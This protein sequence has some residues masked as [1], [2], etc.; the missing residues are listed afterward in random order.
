MVSIRTELAG[1]GLTPR[2]SLGQHFLADQ[3]ILNKVVE[4]ARIEKDDVVLE[5]GSGLGKMTLA[6]AE[7]ARRVIAVEVDLRVARILIEKMAD[8]QNVEV[9]Q[10]DILE[11]DFRQFHEKAG[12]QIK[13]VANLP[14][15]ITT[16]LLFRFVE[17]R[18]IFSSLTLM[19]QKEVAAR[20]TAPPGGKD[21]GILSVFTQLVSD[22]SL[23]FLIKPSA[24]FPPPKVD[25]AVIR[26]AW[27]Q[28]PMADVQDM[29]WFKRVVRG[30]FG[31]RRKTLGNAL[32]HSGLPL[33]LDAIETIRRNGIDPQSR[34]ESLTI[35]EFARL[36]NSLKA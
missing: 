12:Q 3:N 14:Y 7:R 17:S 35:P 9:L 16:P 11:V 6:L 19:I 22:V 30:C 4:A 10:R 26:I 23:L 28:K 20:L 34:P 13:V 27:K 15:Q 33:P 1:H 5:V 21:Y 31:Y 18:D 24:F 36:A 2:K 8:Q 29:E 25:S 32:K